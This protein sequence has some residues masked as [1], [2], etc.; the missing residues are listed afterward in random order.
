M[1]LFRARS[2]RWLSFQ[3][4][5]GT[6]DLEDSGST[7]DHLLIGAVSA[8]P[9]PMSAL[10]LFSGLFGLGALRFRRA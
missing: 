3:P 10:L 6:S 8:V 5:A 1:Y 7:N 4:M 2:S 9:L